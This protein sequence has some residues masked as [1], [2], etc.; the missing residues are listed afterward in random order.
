MR[1]AIG[2]TTC[3]LIG[4]AAEADDLNMARPLGLADGAPTG[5]VLGLSYAK[6]WKP[7]FVRREA[8]A[9]RIGRVGVD[10]CVSPFSGSTVVASAVWEWP[11]LRGGIDFSLTQEQ[12]AADIVGSPL[13]LALTRGDVKVDASRPDRPVIGLKLASDKATDA[14]F[15]RLNGLP[16]LRAIE[17][18]WFGTGRYCTLT[19][20]GLKHLKALK[21]LES[22]NLPVVLDVT[23]SCLVA[24]AE[25]DQLRALELGGRGLRV[26]TDEG[27]ASSA[28]TK[29]LQS[30]NL[31]C[32]I[33]TDEMM[34]S[35]ARMH[36]LK[37]LTLSG[38]KITDKGLLKL[39]ALKNL[40][41]LGLHVHS[42]TPYE[43]R[44]LLAATPQLRELEL[45]IKTET[46]GM[47]WQQRH[48]GLDER[49]VSSIPQLRRLRSLKLSDIGMSLN[50]NTVLYHLQELPELESLDIFSSS[51]SKSGLIQ[52]S[53]LTQL[54]KLTLRHAIAPMSV[55][56]VG[57]SHLAGLTHLEE[58]DISRT[59][60][61]K[62]GADLL[63]KRLPNTR[64]LS[65]T[66]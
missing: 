32:N 40:E 37:R 57:L 18:E 61:T 20:L 26:W 11:R 27:I 21:H 3:L 12:L 43:L 56:D 45:S 54:K 19:S 14:N 46:S 38:H 17:A 64:I 8:P 36:G 58:L 50:L 52:I 44:A 24:L 13:K 23:D 7:V 55:T 16:E 48:D 60:I 51:L 10:T 15:E 42:V 41:S 5:Q 49:C 47:T 25:M 31:Q 53:R 33:I 63:R 59:N 30:L 39:A 4:G 65:W 62:A 9:G 66:R 35:L 29:G 2:L 22:L 1:F 28:T 34:E 6:D